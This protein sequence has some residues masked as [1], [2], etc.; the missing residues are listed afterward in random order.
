MRP[1]LVSI[2]NKE[3]EIFIHS[4]LEDKRRVWLGGRMIDDSWIWMDGTDFSYE[5]WAPG[6]PNN[7]QYL[8]EG[9]EDAIMINWVE[10]GGWNDA[11]K[12]YTF[13][14]GFI[15]QYKAF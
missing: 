6:E 4:L 12:V 13:S 7:N 14:D 10:S 5:N 9:V 11:P 3:E 2:A 15:C 8:Q 1:H